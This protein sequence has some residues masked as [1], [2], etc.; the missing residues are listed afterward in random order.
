MKA[1]DH[2]N[3]A[4]GIFVDLQKAFDTADYSILL[5]KLC[6]YGKPG[7]A[8]KWFQ[9]YLANRLQFAQINGFV[10]K[11]PS[12]FL[13][14]INDLHVAIKH[15]KIHHYADDANL[16]IIN[17]SPKRLN[18]LSNIYLKNLPNWLNANTISLNVSKNRTY[19]FIA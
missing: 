6:Y 11:D 13:L 3:F 18:K 16:L 5:S 2:G 19:Y 4:C 9:S 8:N 14:Y 10:S 12:L 15:C 7:L 17:K 1:H